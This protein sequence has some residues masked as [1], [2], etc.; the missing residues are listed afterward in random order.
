MPFAPKY[1]SPTERISL[2]IP[3]DLKNHVWHQA[4][5]EDMSATDVFVK[6]LR[7]TYD[8]QP[9]APDWQAS[10]RG[11]LAQQRRRSQKRGRRKKPRRK[12][13]WA[14]NSTTGVFE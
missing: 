3:L 10:Q 2:R 8:K 14:G 9:P 12:P 1:E 13:A 11:V 7:K 4:E 5:R 6:I